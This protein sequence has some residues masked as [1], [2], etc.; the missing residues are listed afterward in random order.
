MTCFILAVAIALGFA[1]TKVGCNGGWPEV[2]NT[3]T[4]ECA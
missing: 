1:P 4:C 3:T 2:A